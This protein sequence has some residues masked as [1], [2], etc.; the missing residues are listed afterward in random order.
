MRCLISGC[1]HCVRVSSKGRGS[2][3]NEFQIC[4]CCAHDLQILNPNESLFE[5]YT[6][7]PLKKC[8]ELAFNLPYG[9]SLSNYVLEVLLI[10]PMSLS[11]VKEHL[12]QY[13]IKPDIHVVSDTIGRLRV[14]GLIKTRNHIHFAVEKELV[15]KI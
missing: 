2:S 12:N 1:V 8:S 14:Q 13:G 10:E 11:T 5:K 9:K 6:K 15:I 4:M 3:W 7:Y